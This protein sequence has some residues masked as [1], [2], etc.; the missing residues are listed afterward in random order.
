MD[1]VALVIVDPHSRPEDVYDHPILALENKCFSEWLDFVATIELEKGTDIYVLD[2]GKAVHRCFKKKAYN[3]ISSVDDMPNDVYSN[4]MFCGMHYGRCV[5]TAAN[6]YRT[7]QRNTKVG[8]VKNLSL[9]HPESEWKN[10][11]DFDV[12]TYMW[13]HQNG[14]ERD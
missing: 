11:D 6:V 4:V 7:Y 14:F 9:I 2:S 10:Y 12:A 5:H 1:H 13:S 8:V 3:L